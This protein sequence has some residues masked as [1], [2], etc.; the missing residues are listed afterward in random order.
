M[1]LVFGFHLEK[2][3]QPYKTSSTS[4]NEQD[5]KYTLNL[6]QIL[7]YVQISCLAPFSKPLDW[8]V[9]Q[10]IRC[11]PGSIFCHIHSLTHPGTDIIKHK[12]NNFMFHKQAST[13]RACE[14]LMCP[15]QNLHNESCKVNTVCQ[16]VLSD[17]RKKKPKGQR[18]LNRLHPN[19]N[20]ITNDV[21][22]H[23]AY[24]LIIIKHWLEISSNW[25]WLA[26]GC[27]MAVISVCPEPDMI[28]YG[29]TEHL[30]LLASKTVTCFSIIMKP[31]IHP[32]DGTPASQQHDITLQFTKLYTVTT[33]VLPS[34]TWLSGLDKRI[35]Q[36]LELPR[37]SSPSPYLTVASLCHS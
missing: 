32:A 35:E 11:S 13:S 21:I 8:S 3:W 18:D 6:I 36:S 2:R 20:G 34:L 9:R 25:K 12:V 15:L 30:D 31:S 7:A 29:C 26:R 10:F 5:Q 17:Q 1:P 23:S 37:G 24:Y 33:V 22:I 4:N 19:L 14:I 27:L 16:C 28:A